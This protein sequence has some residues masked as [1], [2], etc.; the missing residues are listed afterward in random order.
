MDTEDTKATNVRT[1]KKPN[2]TS[3]IVIGAA[4]RVHTAL[5]AGVLESACSACLAYEFTKSGLSF[6]QEV[7][8]PVVYEGVQLH[9]A[10]RVDFIVETCL[11]VEVKCVERVLPVHR[12]QLLSYLR[13]SGH[14]LGLLL[15]FNVPHMRQGIHR[16]INGPEAEL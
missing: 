15:N 4:L 5:G 16:V 14:K 1:F 9:T 3:R 10:Y 6:E 2:A 11:V 13:L 12:A 7:R 8:L